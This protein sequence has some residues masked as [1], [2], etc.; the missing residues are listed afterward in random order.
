MSPTPPPVRLLLVSADPARP[1]LCLHVDG[2]GTIAA[3]RYC[4]A[5]NPLPA[6]PGARD[7]LAVP[8]EALRVQWL[9]LAAHSPA[10]A[11]AAARLMLQDRIAGADAQLHIAVGHVEGDAD[12]RP[13]AVVDEACMQRWLRQARESGLQPVTVVPDCLLLDA[14]VDDVVQ[15]CERDGRLLV[16]GHELAFAAE[17]DLAAH[18]LGARAVHRID[19][20]AFEACVASNARGAAALDLLQGP[21]APHDG[22]GRRRRRRLTWLLALVLLSPVLLLAAQ[23]VQRTLAAHWLERRVDSLATAYRASLSGAS[24]PAYYRQRIAPELLALHSA[25]LFEALRAVPGVQLDSYEFAPGTGVRAGLRLAAVQDLDALNLLLAEH[26]LVLVA[27][28]TQPLEQ[29]VH[30]LVA[31]EALQ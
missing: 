24:L 11:L 14:P 18:L 7:V 1:S 10:Q 21:H 20:A 9:D 2:A 22:T 5:A 25:R 16:R 19:S 12:R 13:V 17:P 27:L 28:D 15:V 30:S 6:Q 29:G 8:S 31:V 23:T 4:D 3:R 26:H